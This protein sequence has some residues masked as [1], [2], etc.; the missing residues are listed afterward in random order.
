[1]KKF[2]YALTGII[3]SLKEES[4]F[5]QVMLGLLAVAGGITIKLEP[6]EWLA[7]FICIAMVIS[8]ELVNSCIEKICDMYKREYDERIRTIKDYSAGAVL[9][10]C[11]FSLIVCLYVVIRRI[12]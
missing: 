5:T 2:K 11:F 3:N 6:Y 8:L 9:V 4:V 7:F 1:M 12:V 10:A